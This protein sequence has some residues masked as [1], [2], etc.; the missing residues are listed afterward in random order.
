MAQISREPSRSSES[1]LPRPEIQPRVQDHPYRTG[2]E[3]RNRN[4][5]IYESGDKV[6]LPADS[7]VREA[8]LISVI[9]MIMP[10][11]L[12]LTILFVVIA[13]AQEGS[14]LL[15]ISNQSQLK[16]IIQ[17]NEAVLMIFTDDS[18]QH[19]S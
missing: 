17:D 15:E 12:I 4:D 2:Q 11:A 14:G 13:Q 16:K 7:G 9:I 6:K 10:S 18:C 5:R 1:P 3:G 8:S 19:C